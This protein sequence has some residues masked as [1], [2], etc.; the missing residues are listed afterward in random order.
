MSNST[1]NILD[2][3]D[4]NMKYRNAETEL[5]QLTGRV[6]GGNAATYWVSNSYECIIL[7]SELKLIPIWG[8]HSDIIMFFVNGEAIIEPI[9]D[10]ENAAYAF[11]Y[12][13]V[14]AAI[15]LLKSK[16]VKNGQQSANTESG[17]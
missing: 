2:L 12:C 7:M 8:E 14:R 6:S 11:K 10:H 9:M 5:A 1:V 4:L 16:K 17:A 15:E 3:K 13:L